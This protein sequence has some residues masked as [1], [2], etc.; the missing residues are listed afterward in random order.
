MKKV[1]IAAG[2]VG[3]SPPPP[4]MVVPG[5]SAHRAQASGPVLIKRVSRVMG[6]KD[7]D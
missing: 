7:G 3:V 5:H 4:A 6:T 2:M 1:A